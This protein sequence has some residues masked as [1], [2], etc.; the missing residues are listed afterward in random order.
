M[1]GPLRVYQL[2]QSNLVKVIASVDIDAP[3]APKLFQIPPQRIFTTHRARDRHGFGVQQ[4][5][6]MVANAKLTQNEPPFT[7]EFDCTKMQ[8]LVVTG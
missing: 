8:L 2:F 5:K 3:A 7:N 6:H 1:D 4:T